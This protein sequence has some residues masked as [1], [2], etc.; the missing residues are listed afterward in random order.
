MYVHKKELIILQTRF[1]YLILQTRLVTS[2][3]SIQIYKTQIMHR[4]LL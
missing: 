2:A 3:N 1:I 4:M